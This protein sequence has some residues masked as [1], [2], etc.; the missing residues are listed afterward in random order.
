M[1]IVSLPLLPLTTTLSVCAVAGATA[2]GGGQVGVHVGDAGSGEVVDGD[3]VGTAEGVEV[4]LLDAVRVHRDGAL[5]AEEAQAFT[6]R[7]QVDLLGDVGAVEQHRVGAGLALDG[8]AAVARIPDERVVA[9]AQ[10][11]QVVPSVP[12]DRVVPVAAEQPLGSGAAVEVVVSIVTV[13]RRRDDV[14]EDAV[15]LVDAHEVVAAPAST[16]ILAILS[17]SNWKSAQPSS[18]T[19]TWR[20]PGWP[21]FRRSAIFSLASV[22]T[23]VSRPRLSLGRLNS[24]FLS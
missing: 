9:G 18:P 11:R 21:A 1:L 15:G 17:R 8:V 16:A 7:R 20:M 22:P 19:S 14:G 13:K 6:V 5:G 2:E 4:D 12:V 10:E 23:T 3:D 24:D